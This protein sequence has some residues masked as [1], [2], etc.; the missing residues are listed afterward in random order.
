MYLLMRDAS[1]FGD[2]ST[3]ASRERLGMSECS[4]QDLNSQLN[5]SRISL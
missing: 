2:Q 4:F 5:V 3:F 1:R